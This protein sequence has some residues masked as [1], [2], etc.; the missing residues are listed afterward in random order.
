[1]YYVSLFWN[2]LIF[3]CLFVKA[4][5]QR[6][7]IAFTR[8]KHG[9]KLTSGKITLVFLTTIALQVINNSGR[10]T[11]NWDQVQERY[12]KVD[13]DGKMKLTLGDIL[14]KLKRMMWL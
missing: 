3:L 5:L 7:F 1:M 11:L 4:L 6:Q 14:A 2:P 10:A 8:G 13:K 9:D 12:N